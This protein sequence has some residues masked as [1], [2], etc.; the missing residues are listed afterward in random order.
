M[1]RHHIPSPQ[2]VPPPEHF[3]DPLPAPRHVWS[4]EPAAPGLFIR[5]QL[6]CLAFLLLAKLAFV[7][8]LVWVVFHFVQ[9]FW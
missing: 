8:L 1:Y 7:G 5:V 2:P 3:M 4:S 9:R 6:G